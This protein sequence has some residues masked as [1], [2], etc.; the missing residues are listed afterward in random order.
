MIIKPRIRG[1]IC[2][3]AHP[4][5]LAASVNE[6]IEYVQS[7]PEVAAGLKNVLVIGSGA[8]TATLVPAIA[9]DCKHVTVLQRSPTYF[10]PSRNVNELADLLRELEVDETWIHE[11][12]RRQILKLQADFTQRA[13][14]EPE[15]V[16]KELLDGVRE[17]LGPDYDIETHFTPKYRPWQQRLAFVPDGDLF[18][19]IAAGDASVVTDEIETFTETGLRL[20]SGENL[21]ADIVV[22]ATG[23]DLNVLGDIAFTIDDEPMLFHETVTWRGAMFTG[24]PNM[25]WVFG[26]F[27]ASWTLRVDLLADL[28]I[29]LLDEMDERGA[30]VVVPEIPEADVDMVLAPWVD[31][32]N[33]NPGYI[34]RGL[35]LMPRQGDRQ[36]WLHTQDYWRDK[37]ELPEA[38]FDDGTLRFD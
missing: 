10:F 37:D 16:K 9:A 4:A 26:Y 28:M 34:T 35:H 17:Y 38:S 11:I 25:L 24:I 19:A 5:G 14:E 23:F 8:T 29:R 2:T 36:P 18:Q 21:D 22:T 33:F 13:V 32:E 7:Q 30:S 20:V 1:F 31:P 6:Q 15:V 3:T 12:T 27:R